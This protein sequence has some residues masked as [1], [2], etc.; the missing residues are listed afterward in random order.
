[1]VHENPAV[2]RG[3]PHLSPF[4][5]NGAT[6]SIF[7]LIPAPAPAM[8]GLFWQ[9]DPSQALAKHVPAWEPYTN[10]SQNVV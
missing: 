9:S 2:K 7:G 3:T 6:T 5:N 4:G 10:N 1:M 8:A